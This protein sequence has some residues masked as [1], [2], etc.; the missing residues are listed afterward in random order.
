[1][2]QLRTGIQEHAKLLR[3]LIPKD[4]RETEP[5]CREYPEEVAFEKAGVRIL[6]AEF[7]IL[8]PFKGIDKRYN[9]PCIRVVSHTVR[10][11]MSNRKFR[12]VS[13]L[14]NVENAISLAISR[15]MIR[16]A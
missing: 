1:M 4:W 16:H 14:R 7:R 2:N 8:N 15:S 11:N 9:K 6:A 3:K 12:S 13:P 5:F 10:G